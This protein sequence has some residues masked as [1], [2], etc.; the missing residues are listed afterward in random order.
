[1]CGVEHFLYSCA[2]LLTA[3]WDCVSSD[4]SGG[5]FALVGMSV[6]S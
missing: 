4:M 3:C 5:P 2:V 1:M 6:Q